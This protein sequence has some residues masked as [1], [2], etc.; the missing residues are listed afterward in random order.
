MTEK[1]QQ[2]K[3]A[4]ERQVS[5]LVNAFD[6]AQE[7]GGVWLNKDGKKAPQFYQKGVTISPFNAIILGLHSDQNNYKTNDYTLFSE[8]KKRGE[9]VQS[10]QKGVPFYWYNWNEYQSKTDP[11]VKISRDE[12]KALTPEQQSDYK[13]IRNREVRMLFNIEQ[14]TL[15]MVDKEAF[16][17]E[18]KANGRLADRGDI[19]ATVSEIPVNDLILKMRDNLVDIRLD[20]TGVAHYDPKQDTVYV[21]KRDN[22][23]HYNDYVQALVEQV[24]AATGHTQRLGR[25]G[26]NNRG[27]KT[28]S[29]DAQRQELLVREIATAAKMQELGLPA[30]LSE[31]GMKNIEYWKREFKE[32]PCLIDAIERDVNNALDM[33]H[34]AE[35]GE[36]VEKRQ[37]N[38]Q[39]N[40]N[41]KTLIPKH[42]YVADE[43]KTLPN[44]DTKEMVIVRDSEAKKADVVLPAGASLAVDNEIPGMNKKRIE[45]ALQKAG[46]ETVNF[47]NPDGAL[48]FR[49][50][51]SYFDGKEVSVSKLNKWELE[52]ITKLDVT[53]AV[54]RS[55]AVDF[56]KILMLKDDEGKWA[57]Y[58]KPEN[59]K[60]FSVYPTKDDLNKFFV[61]IQQGNDENTERMR[62]DMATKYYVMANDKPE[63]KVNLFKSQA[64][65]E[66]LARIERVNIFKTKATENK[67]SVILCVPT[68]DGKRIQAR[69]VSPQQWQRLW[70]ADDRQDYKPHLAA[71][72]FADVLRKERT[73][74]VAV[75]TDKTEQEAQSETKEQTKTVEAHE[76]EE[77]KEEKKEEK[78]KEEATK[79]ETKA[80]AAVALSPIFKQFLDLKSKHP[81]ALLLFRTGDFYET[82]KEDAQKA[83]KI[84]GITLTRS[85]KTKDDQGKPLQMAGFPY[86]SLDTYLPKLIRAGER[87][88]ICDQLEAPKQTA[89]RGISELL[90]PS[91]A[92]EKEQKVEQ[93][94]QQTFHR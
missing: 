37:F 19:T 23:E 16:D 77:K 14:T 78:A 43:I 93:E 39:D 90:T 57:M 31:E 94:K 28:P 70:L 41:A 63:M 33:I 88:A 62:Q 49:P 91:A 1:N 4:A 60:A 82:Y 12:Y 40:G 76:E 69:E 45:H 3:N 47:Y 52:D 74:S 89:K 73:N 61:T 35:R 58:L 11:D 7:N 24:V 75:G 25:D 46:Y 32:D 48:G 5:L 15:P 34:K 22:Y 17:K 6:K 85:S 80:V 68:V 8:A 26:M 86:H 65:A 81:D 87:V 42:Y 53:D 50:D 38:A 79:A 66:E 2:E 9:S 36:K 59:E 56:D 54:K 13:G 27:G 84:L 10:G 71:S 92:A 72:H 67:P 20:T 29:E 55:G 51:D 18:V 21:P 83:S 44:K 30:K 64:A